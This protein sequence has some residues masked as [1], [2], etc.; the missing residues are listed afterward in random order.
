MRVMSGTIVAI[1]FGFFPDLHGSAVFLF[2]ILF[3]PLFMF[4]RICCGDYSV[5]WY[6]R[7]CEVREAEFVFIVLLFFAN[8]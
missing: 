8:S 1:W 3:R 5:A 7:N 2:W 4:V 6:M